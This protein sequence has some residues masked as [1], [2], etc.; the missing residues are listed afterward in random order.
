M[1]LRKLQQFV[2][3]FHKNVIVKRKYK[4]FLMIFTNATMRR[5]LNKLYTL[6][7]DCTKREFR[8]IHINA[9]RHGHAIVYPDYALSLFATARNLPAIRVV[10]DPV[11]AVYIV[12]DGNHRLPALLAYARHSNHEYINCEVMS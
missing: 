4:A 9:L 10:F 8:P 1:T 3:S 2:R 12:I 5:D 7:R 11:E 6:S